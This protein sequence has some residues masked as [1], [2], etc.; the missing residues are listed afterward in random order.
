MK[1]IKGIFIAGMLCQ[2]PAFS[3]VVDTIK[4]T[5]TSGIQ[6]ISDQPVPKSVVVSTRSFRE[7]LLADPYRPAYHFCVPEG[8][9]IPGDP[10]GAFY[11]N[12]RYHL[13]YLYYREQRGFSWGHVSSKDMFHWRHHPD[14]I[15]PGKGED[16][17]FS[18]GA[19]VDKDG[20]A[21]LS[22]WQVINLAKGETFQSRIEK[23]GPSGIGLSE[24]SDE[25]FDTWTSGSADPIIRSTEWGFTVTKDEKGNEQ[26]YGSADPS[27]IWFKDG[28]YY[29]LTGNLLVLNKYGRK[30]NDPP[31]YQG[32]HSYLF[33]SEDKKSWKY[34]HEFY[35]SDR[36]WTDKSEDNMCASFLP[37]PA[38]PDGGKLS[39]KHLLLFISHNKGAQYYV[40]DYKNDKFQPVNH[41]RM[42]WVDN[43]YFAPEAL[44]DHKNR[45]IMW[46][47]IFDDRPDKVK[48]ESGWTGVYGLPRSLWAGKDG[49]LRMAPVEEVKLLRQAEQIKKDFVIKDGTELALDGF[50]K[51]LVEL[52]ITV[53]PGKAKTIGVMVGC[54]QDGRE[55]TEIYYDA[56]G[57]TLNVNTAKSSLGYGR[58]VTESA[59]LELDAGEQLTLRVFV[60]KSIVEVFANDKQAIGRSVYPTLGGTGIKLFSKGGDAKIISVKSWEVMPSNPY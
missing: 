30:D 37:L 4:V 47:W 13:M 23:S 31:K 40:G 41:G 1:I 60:D 17:I 25:H 53:A 24:S 59:P 57:K 34:L 21:T 48:D 22:Y 9:G 46:S 7:R 32:D 49:K 50:G 54:S 39:D 10:N 20:K 12:G 3:Q 43:A 18:G 51:E 38:G 5:G 28:K 58:K 44:T 55:K 45:Q 15:V 8:R 26:I 42:T 11:F 29:M 14:A 36:K 56:A 27:N 33:V 16:G 2:T 35:D 19:F 52:E 6:W